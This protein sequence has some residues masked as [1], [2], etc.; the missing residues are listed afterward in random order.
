[1]AD[2][3]TVPTYE[4]IEVLLSK[5][6]TNYSELASSLYDVF[7]NSEPMDVTFQLYNKAGVLQ[8]YTIPNRAKD[9]EHILNGEG[10]P[11]GSVLAS[12]G[13]IY[14][15]LTDGYLYIKETDDG[16]TGWNRFATENF[17][18]T[19]LIVNVG[20]PEGNVVAGRGTLYVD[21]V[22]AGL[23]IKTTITGNTGWQL[24]STSTELLAN[25]DLSN[26]SATGQ[27]ILDG[28]EVKTNKVTSI[29]GSSTDTQYPSALA[30]YTL[31]SGQTS[32]LANKD[33]SNLSMTGEAHFVNPS[34]SN[35]SSAGNLKFV[36]WSHVESG[37]LVAPNGLLQAGTGM[38]D[39]VIP[40]GMVLLLANGLKTDGDQ[41]LNNIISNPLETAVEGGL[42][43]YSIGDKGFIFYDGYNQIARSCTKENFI[44]SDE[45]PVVGS[46]N[47]ILFVNK[48]NTYYY[49]GQLDEVQG[50]SDWFQV[51]M[52]LVGE[53][54]ITTLGT[55]VIIPYYPI[56]LAFE[57]DLEHTVIETGGDDSCWYRLYKDGW[58]EQGGYIVGGGTIIFEKEFK[59]TSYTFV[60]S[61]NV[62][63][64]AKSEGWAI[65]TATS[66]IEVDWMAS[67]WVA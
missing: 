19:L 27:G 33:L 17:L 36:D 2:K 60:V 24:I 9:F 54:E 32:I 41:T 21:T 65:I 16:T 15:D 55:K 8:T 3:I 37:I 46:P 45:V 48:D 42:D 22:G 12:K 14:Q 40:Q 28:K 30:T 20:S 59:N 38:V 1:M 25:V 34:L 4:Q 10:S 47:Q 57:R 64:V 52:A 35:L 50:T 5:L 6:A 18:K 58:V 61:P 67:G 7:F 62:T 29:T 11:E 23:Y 39:F 44:Q 66:G 31:V 51:P 56:R 26:L 49:W 63:S 13:D 43:G 53:F